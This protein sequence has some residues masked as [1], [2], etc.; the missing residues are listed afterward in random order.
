MNMPRPLLLLLAAYLLLGIVYATTTPLFE[1]PDEQW[2]YAFVQHVAQGKGLPQQSIP[3]EHLARQEGSQPPLYYV[4]AAAL[5][6]WVNT[7]D[8]PAIVRENP[9]YGYDVPGIVNDNKNLFIHS[10]PEQFPYQNTSLAIHLARM[11]SLLMGAAAVYFT[12]RLALLL[13]PLTSSNL[14][15]ARAIAAAALV[16]FTPQ[17]LFIS[18]AVSND[19]TIV[20][21]CALALFLLVRAFRVTVTLRHVI[22]IGTVCGLGALAKVSGLAL[23]PLAF[24]VVGYL[25]RRSRRGLILCALAL[26]LSFSV[27]AGWWYVRNLYLYGEVTGTARMLDIFGSRVAPLTADQWHAQLYEVFETYWVGFGW[28]NI[29]APEWVYLAVALA[30]LLGVA[31][32]SVGVWHTRKQPGAAL[33]TYAPL[34]LLGAWAMIVLISLL[35]WMMQTQAPHGRLFFPALPA[36]A[37]LLVIGWLRLVSLAQDVRGR[38]LRGTKEITPGSSKANIAPALALTRLIPAGLF[39]FALVAPFWLLAPAYTLPQILSANEI[40][41][42]PSRVDIRYDDKLMLLGS[43]VRPH[44]LDPRGALQV[45]LYWRVL[46][47]MDVD[48]SLNLSALDDKYRVVGARNTFPGHGTLPTT[49]MAPGLLFHDTYWLPA[50]APTGSVQVT[51][52]SRETQQDIPAYDPAGNEITPIVNRFQLGP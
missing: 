25:N 31:G 4:L 42:I 28:G 26:L 20:A 32:L 19:S 14:N 15:A 35:R 6:F 52:F 11:L 2:H 50:G 1:A 41:A 39:L 16:A 24:V 9:H 36:L 48:Y 51:V 22:L 7:T 21:V 10:G 45:D 46:A 34:L 37:P 3:L 40:P 44:P 43:Q 13:P 30:L 47:P 27:V 5:T 17:F 8:Y 12:F 23:L 33:R 29:R 49:L 38:R 18:S